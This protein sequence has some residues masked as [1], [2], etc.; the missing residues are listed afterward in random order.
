MGARHSTAS[1][2]Q[3]NLP[4]PASDPVG[5]AL[6]IARENA[7]EEQR[8]AIADGV[9]TATEYE[10]A[11]LALAQCMTA[12]GL[13]FYEEPHWDDSGSRIAFQYVGGASRD[14]AAASS[15][16]YESCRRQFSQ[17]IEQIWQAQTTPS[18]QQ[19]QQARAA[20][21]KCLQ[22]AGFDLPDDPTSQELARFNKVEA[23]WPCA[24]QVGTEYRIPNFAG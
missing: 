18:E 16:I 17:E 12:N 13:A 5:F 21:G 8:P 2:G 1:A 15:A 19:L 14:E 23:F 4:N 24:E 10:T 6:A 20:L 9:V 11:M 7:T 22:D 3:H